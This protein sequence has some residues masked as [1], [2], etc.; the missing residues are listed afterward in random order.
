MADLDSILSNLR[1]RID[2]ALMEALPPLPTP[3]RSVH[4]AMHYALLGAGKRI[5]PILCLVAAQSTGNHPETA[6]IPA[7][8]IEMIHAFS[9]VHDDL[10]CMD[11]DDFRR[12]RP[13][14]HKQFSEA[15]ALLAGDA[16][17]ALAFSHIAQNAP[18]FCALRLVREL[19]EA[20][21]SEE[22]IGGQVFDLEAEGKPIAL[23]HLQDIHRRKTGALIRYS[24]RAG[25]VTQEAPEDE[26]M[27]LDRFGTH[28]GILF[29][30]TDDI[31]DIEGDPELLGKP[32]GS[33][34]NNQKATYPAI[35]GLEEARHR[36][37]TEL[38]CAVDAL[39][40]LGKRAE[41]LTQIAEQVLTRH[42]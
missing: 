6:M 10:P 18:G 8:A 5:R 7:C 31:L 32:I 33:D 28:L 20:S 4:E 14:C 29:Q 27:A 39:S 36:A 11:D 37:K 42:R 16:L 40:P 26:I 41:L 15:I 30:I 9:L 21:G 13:T 17:V 34:Q 1:V 22:L 35:M 3:P 23:Q 38:I 2:A 24:L 25:A 19:A 12:G